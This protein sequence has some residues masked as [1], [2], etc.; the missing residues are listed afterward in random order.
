[1]GDR[2]LLLTPS[3]GLGGG[4]ERYIG[5][6]EAAFIREGVDY[7]RVDQSRPGL[8]AYRE[9]FGRAVADIRS[10]G[11]AARLVV[12]HPRL[13]PVAMLV[14]RQADVSGISV[15]CYGADIWVSPWQPRWQLEK[16]I[17]RRADIRVVAIS[18]FTAGVLFAD[19]AATI[20]PAGV[21]QEWF[22]T[23]VSASVTAPP[24]GTGAD[25]VTVFRLADWQDKGLP[26]ILAAIT[27][28]GR[29]DVRLTVL[30]SG[31]APPGL[32]QLV[33][34]HPCCRLRR[35]VDDQ[36]L[37]RQL[38]AADLLVLATRTRTGRQAYG[39]GFGLVLLEAQ[40][41]GTPVI[42]PAYGGSHDAFVDQV[43]GMAPADESV[44][45]LTGVLREMLGDSGR[46]ALMGKRAGE[47]ARETFAPERYSSLV[48]ARLL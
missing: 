1:M 24:G 18:S 28:L 35:D 10:S 12:A 33:S 15:L 43:T 22:D 8:P 39:E 2:A 47:W 13:L 38:A 44:E 46:L 20:L 11:R 36:E 34:R 27:A 6:V 19:R 21:D 4:I 26:E 48:V 29:S 7:G 3:R 42:A 23:L 31:D 40:L 45:A 9:M 14:A 17:I 32:T 16:A 37:A 5:T 30:G 25:L 41:A